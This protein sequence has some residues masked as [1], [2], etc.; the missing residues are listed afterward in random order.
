MRIVAGLA[1]GFALISASRADET[2]GNYALPLLLV[3]VPNQLY[4]MPVEEIAA[5]LPLGDFLQ[6]LPPERENLFLHARTGQA[7]AWTAKG[8]HGLEVITVIPE[9]GCTVLARGESPKAIADQW[10]AWLTVSNSPFKKDN[11]TTSANM[12][13]RT[14]SGEAKGTRLL[15]EISYALPSRESGA[16]SADVRAIVTVKRTN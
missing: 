10:D 14:Y 13:S 4:H 8:N 7:Y 1:L 12:I 2:S 15:A 5:K 11:E 3:C 16:G 6:R 9:V